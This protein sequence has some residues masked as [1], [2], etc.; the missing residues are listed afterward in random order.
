MRLPPE[1]PLRRAF[2]QDCTQTTRGQDSPDH[3]AK[4]GPR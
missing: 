4:N 3:Q 1:A 2:C